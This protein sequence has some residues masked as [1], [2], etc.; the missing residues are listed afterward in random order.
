MI[1]PEFSADSQVWIYAADRFL[2]DQETEKTNALIR[3]FVRE[4]AAHGKGLFA[5]GVVIEHNF[6]V[7][8]ADEKKVQ[9]SG[10]SIDASV[11][12]IKELG[13][14]LKVDFF[15]RLQVLIK[16]EDEFK[17]IPFHDLK[18]YPDWFVYNPMVKN[19]NDLRTNW[20]IPV[21]ESVFV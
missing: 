20:L 18:N 10:C 14:L 4:W 13:K 8:V 9:A 2:D 5:D 16:K 11:H 6:V 3:D 15:N 1:F 17:R 12:F 7:I 19:L 21:N